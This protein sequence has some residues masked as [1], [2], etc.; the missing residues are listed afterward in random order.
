[1]E[2]EWRT[3]KGTN[4]KY[5][6]SNYGEIYSMAKRGLLIPDVNRKGYLRVDI[7]YAD[8]SRKHE[9]VHRLVAIAFLPNIDN[10]PQV[11]HKDKNKANN[12]VSNLEWVTN[13][14]NSNHRW[15]FNGVCKD[16]VIGA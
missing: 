1:M 9:K 3:I 16:M 11:N 2:R 15:N 14:E 5:L 6:V 12:T 10:K 7:N 4:G 13:I 8:G